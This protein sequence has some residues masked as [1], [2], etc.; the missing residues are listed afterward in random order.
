MLAPLSRLVLSAE[1]V[2]KP[3][4]IPGVSPTVK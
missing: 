2:E 1:V 3:T 4:N